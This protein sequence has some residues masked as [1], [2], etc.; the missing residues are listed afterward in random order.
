[1]QVHV[2]LAAVDANDAR[3]R[4]RWTVPDVL[5]VTS[6]AEPDKLN[7]VRLEDQ[8]WLVGGARPD[9]DTFT[10]TARTDAAT[11]SALRLEVLP[12][13][14]LPMHGPGRYDNGNFHLT[15]LHVTARAAVGP[16]LAAAPVAIAHAWA[17]HAEADQPLTS[18]LD[19][20]PQTYWALT[21]ATGKRTRRCSS[22]ANRSVSR[23]AR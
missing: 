19:D 14:S 9:K 11:I 16:S 20:N 13:E 23:A 4:E 5:S 18:V 7:F 3:R 1:M 17:D 8:S 10:I 6:A 12:D 15:E 22:S 21:R 2:E